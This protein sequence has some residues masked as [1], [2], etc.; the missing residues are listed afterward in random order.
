MMAL[1]WLVLTG[2]HGLIYPVRL[3]PINLRAAAPPPPNIA[4]HQ[5]NRRFL[6]LTS[7]LL[8]CIPDNGHGDDNDNNSRNNS[9]NNKNKS[10]S[11]SSSTWS[12]IGNPHRE[13][14]S[15]GA[16]LS[17]QRIRAAAAI[18]SATHDGLST[19]TIRL[20]SC[21]PL[22]SQPP[23]PP[24]P[25][26]LPA[27]SPPRKRPKIIAHGIRPLPNSRDW[28]LRRRSMC[29]LVHVLPPPGP[30]PQPQPQ[31]PRPMMMTPTC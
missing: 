18:V 3:L 29:C 9:N 26:P 6:I 1:G 13:A 20:P 22:G 14:R 12:A 27:A 25:I 17:R 15:T 30:R 11:S 31:Q 23:C 4:E 21:R 10:S 28:R 16:L 7:S 2:P 19:L 5:S 8:L 24:P